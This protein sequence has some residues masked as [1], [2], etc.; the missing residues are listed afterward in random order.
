MNKVVPMKYCRGDSCHQGRLPCQ[1]P[2]A[3]EVA[4]DDDDVGR[5]YVGL[6]LLVIVLTCV[7]GMVWILAR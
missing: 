2:Q 5:D 3:C 1:T 6:V 4:E 7:F